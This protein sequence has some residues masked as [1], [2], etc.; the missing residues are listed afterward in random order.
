MREINKDALY[1]GRKIR[2]I[3]Q[4]EADAHHLIIGENL[5]VLERGIL[6]ELSRTSPE[7]LEMKL[8]AV[9]PSSDYILKSEGLTYEAV[10]WAIAQ[11]RLV[12]LEDELNYAYSNLN[13][14]LYK[15]NF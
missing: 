8:D 2:I 7:G 4:P 10:G 15:S 11:A 12:E 14:R 3:Y 9:N 13:Q 6:D 1:E 5:I